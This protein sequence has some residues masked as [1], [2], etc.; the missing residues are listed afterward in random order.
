MDLTLR[1]EWADSLFRKSVR[2]PLARSDGE[3]VR[4]Q[5]GESEAAGFGHCVAFLMP[6]TMRNVTAS[7]KSGTLNEADVFTQSN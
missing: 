7:G 1:A 4:N 6:T 5:T 2:A 3:F